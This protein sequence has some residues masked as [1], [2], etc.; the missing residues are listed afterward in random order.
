[1]KISCIIVDDEPLARDLLADNI[2]RIPYLEIKGEF[3]SS[4]K[5]KEFL[6]KNKIDLIFLDIQMPNMSGIE[7]AKTIKDS[8]V[9]FTTAFDE[10]AL[11][12]FEVSAIDYVLKPI[13][14]ERFLKACEKAKEYYEFK[15][16]KLNDKSHVFLRADHQTIKVELNDIQYIEGLKDYVKVYTKTQVKPIITRT[17]LKGITELLND[18]KFERVHKSYIVNLTHVQSLQNDCLLLNSC[19]V[20]VGDA[21]KAAIKLKFQ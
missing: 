1:M 7:L 15:N 13:L 10:Y 9:I 3:N 4:I 11:E 20:P 12:G 5:A 21:Y 17:N 16:G 14:F 18:N 2:K 8:M 19:K 6:N